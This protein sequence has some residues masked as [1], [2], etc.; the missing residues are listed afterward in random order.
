MAELT[1]IICIGCPK[2]CPV[3]IEHEDKTILNI[4]G[5]RCKVGQTYAENEF[6]APKRVFTS[7]VR[8][9]NGIL[10]ML[11]VKTDGA[12]PKEK[13]FDLA[14]FICTLQAEAPVT[15]GDVLCADV[16]GTG[17]NLIA[18]RDVAKL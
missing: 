14:K 11:P 1:K 5:Y 3:I 15:S 6:T 10:A 16:C 7:T 2:G 13:I 12:I 9:H 18:T 17:V 8:I 4:T